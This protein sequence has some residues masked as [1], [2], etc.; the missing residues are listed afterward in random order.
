MASLITNITSRIRTIR[1]GLVRMLTTGK[2]IQMLRLMRLIIN[3]INIQIRY[4]IQITRVIR[5]SSN[6]TTIITKTISVK[7]M[8][9]LSR[10]ISKTA[11]LISKITTKVQLSLI[12]TKEASPNTIIIIK[13]K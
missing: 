1:L 4:T 10:S 3:S 5:I 2:T 8:L 6:L 13:D 7:N 9:N 12:L 11:K